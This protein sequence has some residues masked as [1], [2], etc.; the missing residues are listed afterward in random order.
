MKKKILVSVCAALVLVAATWSQAFATATLDG[1]SSAATGGTVEFTIRGTEMG[2]SAKIK[3]TGLEFVKAEGGLSDEDVLILLSDYGG[4][5]AKYTYTVTA[6]AGQPVSFA[7]TDLT[8]SDGRA[9][10][11]IPSL[12]W[13]GTVG[14]D[15]TTSEGPAPTRTN[16]PVPTQTVTNPQA[17]GGANGQA[18]QP[19]ATDANGN[20]VQTLPPA[21]G[22]GAQSGAPTPTPAQTDGP[23]TGDNTMSV[24]VWWIVGIAAAIVA[25]FAG[26]KAF[27]KRKH[28]GGGMDE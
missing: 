18:G 3:T 10:S 9:D 15:I 4:M 8:E 1:P 13:S 16:Q 21:D 2:L 6:A 14:G 19:A 22:A 26:R 12:T 20:P 24:W 17:A 11:Y 7:L 23:R 25:V 5:E 27:M 28:A